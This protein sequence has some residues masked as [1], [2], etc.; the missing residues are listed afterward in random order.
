MRPVGILGGTFDP[1][2]NGHLAAAEGACH[3]LGLDRVYLMPNGQPPHKPDQPVTPAHHRRA[4][5]ELVVEANPRLAFLAD[6]VERAEPSYTV[7]TL[8]RLTGAHPDWAIHFIVGMDSLINL[9]TWREPEAILGMASLIVVNRPGFAALAGEA[10]IRSL[11]PELQGRV[12]VLTL[13]GVAVAARELRALAEVGY[14]LRYLVPDAVA[15]YAARHLLYKG[16]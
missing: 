10:V 8:R 14:P 6:E 2:H 12:R 4:M 16:G 7:A 15:E 11:P 5:V 1:V 9:P 13:P 3:L